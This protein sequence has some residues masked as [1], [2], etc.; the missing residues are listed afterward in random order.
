MNKKN[1]VLTIVVLA[2]LFAGGA[3]YYFWSK[4]GVSNTPN[5]ANENEV[6][7]QG[8]SSFFDTF[9]EKLRPSD[10]QEQSNLKEYKDTVGIF[11]INYLP[12]WVMRSEQGRLLS[13]SSLTPP[14]LLSQYSEEERQFVK[15]L[16]VAAAESQETPEAYYRGLVAGAETGQ[17][18]AKNLTI[19]G[20]PAY[21]VR[22]NT[23]GIFYNIY[24]VSHNN[25][26]V[27]FNYRTREEA[28]AHQ[29]DIQKAVDFTPY[30]SDFEAAIRSIKFLK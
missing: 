8:G 15:G 1:I 16:V 30:V 5:T 20:Y 4:G 22:G 18:E 28:S 19:N 26:I 7:S 17:T 2:I 13:G 12:S 23:K 3:G 27:Y 24:I 6:A 9:F 25:R 21:L 29:N 11:S 10:K 14:E